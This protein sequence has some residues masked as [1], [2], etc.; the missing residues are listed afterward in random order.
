MHCLSQ[1][2][3]RVDVCLN[4][5]LHRELRPWLLCKAITSL[6][7][8]RGNRREGE[9]VASCIQF[10]VQKTSMDT[11][12]VIEIKMSHCNDFEQVCETLWHT[13]IS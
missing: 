13:A 7:N 5:I 1:P 8:C 6:W 9:P 10:R 12:A 4:S 11:N 2:L 3:A